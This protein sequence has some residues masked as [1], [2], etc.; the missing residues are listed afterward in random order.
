VRP[1]PGNSE[2]RRRVMLA[3][4][5]A[6]P[7]R[8]RAGDHAFRPQRYDPNRA[9]SPPGPPA[10][11]RE[12]QKSSTGLDVSPC[13]PRMSGWTR[14]WPSWDRIVS[15]RTTRSGRCCPLCGNRLPLN[16]AAHLGAQLPLLVRA[17]YYDSWHPQ[18][19]TS[20]ERK[21]AEFLERVGAGLEGIRPIDVKEATQAV[22]GVIGRHVS[23]GQ[24]E[25]VRQALPKDILALWPEVSATEQAAGRARAAASDR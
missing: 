23:E 3:A 10:A 24:V 18:P 17:I 4:K 21:Q 2:A 5:N 25:K 19:D 6:S 1:D 22:F 11:A 16:L 8:N 9:G 14:S 13:K 12:D 15:A 7:A 20:R